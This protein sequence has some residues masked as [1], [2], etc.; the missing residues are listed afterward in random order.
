M[1]KVNPIAKTKK[2]VKNTLNINKYNKLLLVFET[3]LLVGVIDE[4]L[5]GVI[6]AQDMSIYLHVLTLMLLVGFIFTFAFSI[7]EPIIKK[8]VAWTIR[9][10]RNKLIRVIIHVLILSILYYL[11]AQVFF[12]TTIQPDIGIVLN[13]TN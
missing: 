8:W 9:F 11:Y 4:Y 10:N 12:G 2:A 5:E 1:K 7:I 6:L 3:V 13:L